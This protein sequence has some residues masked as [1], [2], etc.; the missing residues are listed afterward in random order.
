MK[1]ETPPEIGMRE[2]LGTAKRKSCVLLYQQAYQIF[3]DNDGGES[4]CS[5]VS[6]GVVLSSRH[7]R[8]LRPSIPTTAI[9]CTDPTAGEPA[10]AR[11]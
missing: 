8:A 11:M 3:L 5:G 6:A 9:T 4:I 10:D 1:S 2:K 7:L